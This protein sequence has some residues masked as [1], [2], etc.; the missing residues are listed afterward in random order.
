MTLEYIEMFEQMARE[1]KTHDIRHLLIVGD[2][3]DIIG[4]SELRFL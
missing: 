2:N 4:K 1:L 3:S